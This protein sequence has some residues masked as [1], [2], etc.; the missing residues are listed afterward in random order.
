MQRT[1]CL[2]VLLSAAGEEEAP[3]GIAHCIGGLGQ[4]RVPGTRNGYHTCTVRYPGKRFV[5]GFDCAPR[6]HLVALGA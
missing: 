6:G 2:F 4:H 1:D 5:Q 3:Y